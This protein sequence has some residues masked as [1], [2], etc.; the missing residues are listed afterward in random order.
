MV[1]KSD[2][3]AGRGPAD[4]AGRGPA[5]IGAVTGKGARARKI[6]PERIPAVG[7]IVMSCFAAQATPAMRRARRRLLRLYT[8]WTDIVGP[9]HA[10]LFRPLSLRDSRRSAPEAG[11]D[12]A[13]GG[14]LYVEAD[15][16]SALLLAMEGGPLVERI[17][18]YFGCRLVTD[19]RPAPSAMR[20]ARPAF[21]QMAIPRDVADAQQ[22]S[23]QQPGDRPEP[24][25][26][27]H[28]SAI[29][30]ERL[31]AAL[32]RLGAEMARENR[33]GARG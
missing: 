19:I 8:Y 4:T 24:H 26:C 27:R 22:S 32:I 3:A 11:H 29:G 1:H 2:Q 18:G 21:A 31:R 16:A 12:G 9:D 30:D 17:N 6:P 13:P 10:R 7:D 15:S 5:D 25:R 20:R 28:L 33:P 14:V 23:R